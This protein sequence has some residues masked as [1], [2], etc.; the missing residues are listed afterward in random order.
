MCSKLRHNASVR[1]KAAS[2]PDLVMI[3]VF[4]AL[5]ASVA[6]PAFLALLGFLALPASLALPKLMSQV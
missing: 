1:L 3:L 6:L 4:L 5:L 2:E